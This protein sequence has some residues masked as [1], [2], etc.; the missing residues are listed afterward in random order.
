MSLIWLIYPQDEDISG[1]VAWHGTDVKMCLIL[2]TS[3]LCKGQTWNEVQRPPLSSH[4]FRPVNS[5]PSCSL[6][7]FEFNCFRFPVY[8]ISIGVW[9]GKSLNG[10]QSAYRVLRL[11]ANVPPLPR[12]SVWRVQ[13]HSKFHILQS[14]VRVLQTPERFHYFQVQIIS[15]YQLF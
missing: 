6:V 7:S 2:R 4:N 8:R 10:D 14:S 9:D 15:K 12:T 11:R 1:F 13:G 3:C 5:R